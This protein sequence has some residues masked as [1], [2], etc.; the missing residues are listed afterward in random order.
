MRTTYAQGVQAA[1]CRLYRR[2]EQVSRERENARYGDEQGAP[3]SQLG[4]TVPARALSEA[5]A[6]RQAA[7]RSMKIPAP[8]AGV[9][10]QQRELQD[11]L[12]MT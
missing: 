11:F 3:G 5:R 9:S 6:I 1:N 4:E 7:C 2:Y 10:A 8:C 12:P